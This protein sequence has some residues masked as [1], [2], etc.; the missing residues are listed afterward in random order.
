[1]DIKLYLEIQIKVYFY[2]DDFSGF[3]RWIEQTKSLKAKATFVSKI[4]D[5]VGIL[6]VES[7]LALK[8]TYPIS[9]WTKRKMLNLRSQ[10]KFVTMNHA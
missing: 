9:H 8:Q 3:F 7:L 4:K 1:M 6:G 10:Q 5:L 2:L